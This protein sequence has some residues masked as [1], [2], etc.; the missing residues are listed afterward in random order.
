MTLWKWRDYLD[1]M[2]RNV[3]VKWFKRI[4]DGA[5][6]KIETRMLMMRDL[7]REDWASSWVSPYK[8]AER[9]FEL[10]IEHKNVQYRPLWFFGPKQRQ[11]TLLIGATEVGD[12]IKP[13][14][15]PE[16]AQERRNELLLD[17]TRTINHEFT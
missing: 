1:H 15:A 4:P 10:R 8:S 13:R 2:G 9:I 6:A 12:K 5:V 11:L 3:I 17:P 16:T 14:V 7:P